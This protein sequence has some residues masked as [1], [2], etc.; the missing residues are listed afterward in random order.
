MEETGITDPTGRVIPQGG[1]NI[2]QGGGLSDT[3]VWVGGVGT[4]RSN[5]D[6]GR[7]DAHWVS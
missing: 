3:N 6:E 5:G 1:G 7:R 2:L 4:F